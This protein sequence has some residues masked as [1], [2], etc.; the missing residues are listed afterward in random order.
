MDIELYRTFL[1]ICDSKSFTLAAQ[2]V[3][4]TQSAVSQQV[5][6][7]EEMLGHP[8]FERSATHVDVTQF[9]KALIAH[10]RTIVETQADVVQTFRRVNFA[11]TF[12]VGVAD[13]YVNRVLREV[14]VE[15]SKILPDAAINIVI[16]DSLGLSR[17]VADG[18][19]DFAFITEG[20][21][22]TRGPVVFTDRVVVVGPET[23]ELW[24]ADPLPL[25]VWDVRNEDEAPL[26]KHLNAQ[27]RGYRNAV[28][29]R[30]VSAQHMAITSRLGVGVLVEGSMVAGERAYLEKEGFPVLKEVKVHLDR[31]Y[32]KRSRTVQRLHDHYLDYFTSRKT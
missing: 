16:D 4:R 25:V 28:V 24:K 9:G 32:A 13:A 22:P 10:A 2:Q 8:L 30:S 20:N 7:L 23:G 27:G 26:I 19:V 5:K 31:S 11:G 29:C 6:R 15:F 21:A 1:A 14:L 17:R 3:N 18:S 12:V